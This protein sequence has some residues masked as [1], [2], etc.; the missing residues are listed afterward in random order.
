MSILQ[1]SNGQKS[2][3][4]HIPKANMI[5]KNM[6]GPLFSKKKLSETPFKL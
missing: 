3:P 6:V 5:A 4:L 1:T 2:G